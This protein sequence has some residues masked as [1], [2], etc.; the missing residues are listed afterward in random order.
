M[1]LRNDRVARNRES[2]ADLTGA[3]VAVVRDVV[4]NRR[5]N[6]VARN[7]VAFFVVRRL[8]F[9]LNHDVAP[10]VQRAERRAGFIV[11]NR[12][13][14]V[15]REITADRK[16]ADRAAFRFVRLQR[17]VRADR[18]VLADVHTA[19]RMTRLIADRLEV[20]ADRD[21]TA[22]VRAAVETAIVRRLDA[23]RRLF[24]K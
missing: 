2:A 3:V 1:V 21:V 9:A 13:E 19:D 7:N 11:R 20:L 6:G 18:H 22:D 15:D 23:S 12:G 10:Y 14:S 16:R 17:R 4:C 5:R 24:G 8:N